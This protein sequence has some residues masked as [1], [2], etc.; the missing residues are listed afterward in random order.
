VKCQSNKTEVAEYKSQLDLSKEKR[1]CRREKGSIFGGGKSK[2]TIRTGEEVQGLNSAGGSGIGENG[3]RQEPCK[4]WKKSQ[5][6]W[7]KNPRVGH[8]KD[9]TDVRR[10]K[11]K[12][13]LW[14]KREGQKIP[15]NGVPEK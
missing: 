13:K 5:E 8:R 14:D 9:K 6:W 15:R 1:I 11:R 2:G 3:K 10:K 12:I 4:S 7:E